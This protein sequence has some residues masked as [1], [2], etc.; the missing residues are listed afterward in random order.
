MTPAREIATDLL[1]RFPS[2]GTRTLAKV[3]YKQAP[4]VFVTLEAARTLFRRMRGASGTEKQKSASNKQFFR[5]PGKSGDPFSKLPEGKTHFADWETV[6][7]DGERRILLLAD[8]HIPYH[9]RRAT[10][11]ALRYGLEH[12]ADTIL[13]NGDVAD[14]F[15]VS[16]WE[17]DPRKRDFADEVAQVRG[18]L[19]LVREAFPRARIIYK[20]GNHE[21]RFERY[22]SVK[23]PELLGLEEF[24]FEAVYRL[25]E[26]GIELVRDK[27]PIRFGKLNVVHGHEYR[28]AIS[29][30]VNPARGYFLRAKTHCI[31]SHLHQA[32]QHS[33]KNIEGKLIST[34][35]TGCLCEMHPDY[36]PINNWGHGFAF[37]TVDKAGDFRVTNLRVLDGKIY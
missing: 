2:A 1:H 15:S 11:A 12:K 31:G 27:R 8:I 7:I 34:W 19:D 32:S 20:L 5:K 30:P 3:A 22:M 24:S 21:E 36:A 25:E 14:C 17:K 6:Q 26:T 29:N 18:F 33:E 10:L 13:L 16:F 35:S 23:A 4:Q 37:I 28:F 9:D